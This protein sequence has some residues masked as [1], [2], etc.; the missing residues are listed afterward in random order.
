ML[1]VRQLNHCEDDGLGNPSD[2]VRQVAATIG[3]A[4]TGKTMLARRLPTILPPLTPPESLETTRIYSA[5]GG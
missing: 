1:A 2:I 3:S 4:G 5:L